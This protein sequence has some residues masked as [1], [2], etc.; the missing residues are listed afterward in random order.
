M[1]LSFLSL[2]LNLQAGHLDKQL[3]DKISAAKP[4][5]Q[6]SVLIEMADQ[7]D[8]PGLKAELK[9]SK[10]NLAET[11]KRVIESLKDKADRSQ[12]EI[13]SY[14]TAAKNSGR[15]SDFR[16]FWISNLIWVKAPP[17]EIQALSQR[18]DVEIIF[19]TP[20][21]ELVKPVEVIVMD[22]QAPA[23]VTGIETGI[24]AIRA[25]RLWSQGYKGK[26]RLVCNIDTGV[27]KNHST[28][29]ARWRGNFLLPEKYKQAWYDPAYGTTTPNDNKAGGSAGHGTGTMSVICG[30]RNS[31]TGD[32]LG[33]APE[34]LWIA[35]QA[36]DI[37]ADWPVEIG[38]MQWASDPDDDPNTLDDVPDVVNNSWGLPKYTSS[39]GLVPGY[40]PCW[41]IYW[42]VLDH[43]AA[44]GPVVAFAA[45]N[46]GACGGGVSNLR[47]PADR[48]ASDYN[49]FA[50]GSFNGADTINFPISSFS[51]RGPSPC[52]GVTKKPEVVAPG[53]NVEAAYPGSYAFWT[54]TS[55]SAPH[56]AGAAA[57]LKQIN[58]DATSEEILRALLVTARDKGPLGDDNS[59]GRGVIDVF[60][61]KDSL[62]PANTPHIYVS[63]Y[64][65][66]GDGNNAPDPGENVTFYP[67]V[68]NDGENA[69]NV[70]L[71]L[72]SNTPLATVSDSTSLFGNMDRFDTLFSVDFIQFSTSSSAQAGDK[73]PF[74]LT[75][76]DDSGYSVNYPLLFYVTARPLQSKANHDKG[77]FILTISNFGQYGFGTISVNHGIAPDTG[78]G[79]IYPKAGSDNLFEAAVLFG[80]P[81]AQVSDAARDFVGF[82]PDS[83]FVAAPGGELVLD[84]L[85]ASRKSDQ[86]GFGCFTDE[87]AESPIG[88][89]IAQ[90]SYVFSDTANDDYVIFEFTIHNT[91]SSD[92]AG[93]R[94]GF[95]IDFDFPFGGG[96]SDRAGFVR[97]KNLGYMFQNPGSNYRGMVVT[98][99][100]G[101]TSFRAIENNPTL[102][103]G[104]FDTEKWQFMSGGFVDTLNAV[105]Q[106][107]SMLIACGP[108]NIPAGDSVKT[109]FALVG[110]T[111]LANLDT[112]AQRAI[113][114]YQA[115][116][117]C[118]AVPGDVNAS[119]AITIGDIVHLVNY[120]FDKDRLPCLGTDPG[121]CWTPDP[122]CRGD[123]NAS[124]SI[125]I[126]DV[127]HLVNYVFDKDRL[128][129]LGSDPGNC[130]TPDKSSVCC[131]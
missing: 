41:E 59:Y 106:D 107:G 36:I 85:S 115:Y 11:H 117:M 131:Q 8:M 65:F 122:F 32:T 102:Y 45:G 22:A 14:L 92:L 27:D 79:F 16:P 28:L 112:F 105:A 121:N 21:V 46:E 33:V 73:L 29:S 23:D 52:D 110:A 30:G 86:D 70:R 67:I 91:G 74:T 118:V 83:D 69:Y 119:G 48:I 87:K 5:E 43:L 37:S 19:L 31:A 61:A 90:R 116:L 6:I 50:V 53:E 12:K 2:T 95:F 120:L 26:G 100:L 49:V 15:I 94:A 18:K 13:I 63:E 60:A 77:N 40:T 68:I 104:F 130:W 81:T 89:K 55:F 93:L 56:V 98:D 75:I 51:S 126:G 127:V 96:G 128:P 4:E 25:D 72:S 17:V 35:A 39:C 34:A 124:A 66:L 103:D 1:L 97:S 84:T 108:W 80:L 109:S 7:V 57:L 10:A 47:V 82:L 42:Q 88:L 123:V 62:P 24:K 71:T 64:E 44:A 9:A 76:A 113:D 38:A 99:T 54:G 101:V 78:V 114:K 20:K 129:C 111:S 3:A 125:T 58:P